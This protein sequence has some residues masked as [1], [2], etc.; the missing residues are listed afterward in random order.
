MFRACLIAVFLSLVSTVTGSEYYLVVYV[1]SRNLNYISSQAFIES[2]Q[3]SPDFGHAWIYLKGPGSI[4]YGGHSGERGVAK[5]RYFDGVMEYLECADPNPIKYLWEDLSDGFM[6]K[7][8]GGHKATT[9]VRISLNR[10]QWISALECIQTYDF[11]SYSLTQNQCCC[12]VQK[13]LGAVG[14]SI[15]S[16]VILRIDEIVNVFGEHYRIR[17]DE[18]YAA[19]TLFTPE[20][21]EQKL[22]DLFRPRRG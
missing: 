21:L 2:M 8:S 19:I 16:T 5:P 12:F 4:I 7:G 17:S 14:I 22:R 15:D 18:K 13:V 6:Q 1:Q 11:R 3:N 10:N 20:K 9:A